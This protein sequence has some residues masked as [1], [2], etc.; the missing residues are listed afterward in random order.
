MTIKYYLENVKKLACKSKEPI[1][2]AEDI[3]VCD[4]GNVLI[5][6]ENLEIPLTEEFETNIDNA[7]ED[8]KTIEAF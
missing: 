4:Y 1:D 5:S 7:V 6:E 8:N 3:I 2:K